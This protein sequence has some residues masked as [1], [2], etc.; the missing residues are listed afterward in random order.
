MDFP[1]WSPFKCLFK[2]KTKKT[3]RVGVQPK[4]HRFCQKIDTPAASPDHLASRQGKHWASPPESHLMQM[5]GI[6]VMEA[7]QLGSR[8][9]CFLELGEEVKKWCFF[10]GILG[11]LFPCW[12]L[13]IVFCFFGRKFFHILSTFFKSSLLK[14]CFKQGKVKIG[15]KRTWHWKSTL[16]NRS[17]IYKWW[18]LHCCIISHPSAAFL[19]ASSPSP[20]MW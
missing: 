16:S 1:W 13:I 9:F 8:A 20:G 6:K 5:K 2:N 14:G 18:M 17:Y 12:W 10:M 3:K 7:F 19:V 4:I 15:K 11:T